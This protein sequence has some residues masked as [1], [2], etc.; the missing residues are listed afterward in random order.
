MS[1][2]NAA[3]RMQRVRAVHANTSFS[4]VQLVPAMEAFNASLSQAILG[5]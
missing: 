4:C 3:A 2:S 5:I 1:R